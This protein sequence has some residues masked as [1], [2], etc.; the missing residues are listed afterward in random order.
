MAQFIITGI[1]SANYTDADKAVNLDTGM[2]AA[3]NIYQ[4]DGSGA[5][6]TVE[7]STT[8]VESRSSDEWV[9]SPSGSV[10]AKGGYQIMIPGDRGIRC[11]PDSGTWKMIVTTQRQ[12]NF[13]ET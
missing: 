9:S 6:A 13:L 7:T 10:T 5:T 8:Q 3:I 2:L 12:H 11:L 1:T 4:T